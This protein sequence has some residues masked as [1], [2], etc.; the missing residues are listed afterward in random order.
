MQR[1]RMSGF[2]QGST[3]LLDAILPVLDWNPKCTAFSFFPWI[4]KLRTSLAKIC[5]LSCSGLMQRQSKR[6]KFVREIIKE[7]AGLA[8]YERR[9][10]ELLKVGRDKRALKLCKRK[11]NHPSCVILPFYANSYMTPSNHTEFQTHSSGQL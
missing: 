1:K 7:V 5:E 9:V 8:P 2:W 3:L 4:I 11:V 10:T 6:V